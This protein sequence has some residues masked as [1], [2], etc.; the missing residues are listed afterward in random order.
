MIARRA[1]ATGT[2]RQRRWYRGPTVKGRRACPT[3]FLGACGVSLALLAAGCGGGSRQDAHEPKGAFNLEVVNASF[4]AHQSIAR[5]THLALQVRNSGAHIVPNVAV[6][7][8]SFQ[9]TDHY[10]ELASN[11]RPIWAVEQGPGTSAAR[12]VDTQAVSPPGGGATAY[13]STWALGPL[14]P[15]DTQTFHWLVM[16]LKPGRHTVHFTVAAG[17]SGKARAQLAG[18]AAAVGKLTVN[19]APRTPSNHVDPN[20]GAVVPGAFPLTP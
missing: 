13:V 10:P 1:S 9:Y 3:L 7:I 12:P 14:A 5:E 16:P 8:D 4:P 11:Q 18:G 17:L 15:G 20:S 6:S 2:A 19:I